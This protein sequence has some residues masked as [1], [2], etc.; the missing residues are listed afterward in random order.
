MDVVF[1]KSNL[2]GPGGVPR[3]APLD[4]RERMMIYLQGKD[5]VRIDRALE[6]LE[7]GVK[8]GTV[9]PEDLAEAMRKVQRLLRM[10]R[11]A[12]DLLDHIE[13]MSR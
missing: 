2:G 11:E 4:R 5:S 1:S 8:A 3:G 10:V 6:R 12:D 7:A 9:R 13:A